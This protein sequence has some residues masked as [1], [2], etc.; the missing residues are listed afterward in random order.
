MASYK[1]IQDIEADD[2]LLGPLTLRQFIYA[3]IGALFVYLSYIVIIKHAPFM[4]VLFLPI[5]GIAIFFAF[6]WKLNQPTEV[7]ALAKIRFLFLPKNRRWDQNGVKSIVIITAPEKIVT[8]YTKGLTAKEIDSRLKT[9]AKTI[10]SRGWAIKNVTNISSLTQPIGKQNNES[11][12]LLGITITPTEVLSADIAAADD[13]LDV[14]SS[15]IAKHLD[16]MLHKYSTSKRNDLI[17]N[18]KTSQENS[19]PIIKQVS[20][21]NPDWFLSSPSAKIISPQLQATAPQ[22]KRFHETEQQTSIAPKSPISPPKTPMTETSYADILNLASNNDLNITTL[23]RQVNA[24]QASSSQ[25]EV[26]ISLH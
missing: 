16:N 15:S 19:S 11:D 4:L 17:A 2:K 8:D 23:A 14:Q 1:I 21:T 13:I 10:D 12:R 9:L 18:L 24:K 25:N 5:I 26:V 7:W 22:I 6:P 20:S 3:G